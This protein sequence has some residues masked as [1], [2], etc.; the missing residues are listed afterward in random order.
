MVGPLGVADPNTI[1]FYDGIGLFSAPRVWWT[2]RV[3]GAKNVYILDGGLPAW[4]ADG[5][6]TEAGEVKQH[7]R[8]F[9]TS[10]DVGA[11]AMLSDVLMALNDGSAQVVDARSARPSARSAPEPRPGPGS[12]HTA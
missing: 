10:M 2:F 12:G 5:R 8:K 9:N 3:F 4:T 1:V 11:V 6:P 7:P